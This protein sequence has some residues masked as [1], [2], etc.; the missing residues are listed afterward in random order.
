MGFRLF[1]CVNQIPKTCLNGETIYWEKTKG[2][3]QSLEQE[4]GHGSCCCLG[5]KRLHG[6]HSCQLRAMLN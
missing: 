5:E 4:V 3:A 1:F 6:S 2:Y